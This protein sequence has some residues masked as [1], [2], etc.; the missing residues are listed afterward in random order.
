M[1]QLTFLSTFNYTSSVSSKPWKFLFSGKLGWVG[2]YTSN[3]NGKNIGGFLEVS[4]DHE[5][6]RDKRS[7]GQQNKCPHV[8]GS[9]DRRLTW[10]KVK[11]FILKGKQTVVLCLKMNTFH[12]KMRTALWLRPFC[13]KEAKLRSSYASKIPVTK[14]FR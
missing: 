8:A 14:S 1:A 3:R 9:S 6:S 4:L 5:V 7:R 13:I 11:G 12:N 10:S 2:R